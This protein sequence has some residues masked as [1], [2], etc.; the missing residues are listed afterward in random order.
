[1]ITLYIKRWGAGRNVSYAVKH[2]RSFGPFPPRN[3]SEWQRIDDAEDWARSQGDTMPVQVAIEHGA[4]LTAAERGTILL[5]SG[6]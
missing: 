5:A 6:I 4:G 2:E 3:Y 1:M